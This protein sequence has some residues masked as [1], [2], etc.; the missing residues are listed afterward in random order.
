MQTAAPNSPELSLPTKLAYSV[1]EACS[2]LS[3]GKTTIYELI[4]TGRLRVVRI[5]NRTLVTADAL[6]ALLNAEDV[7]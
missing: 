4:K 7:L 1:K 5:G 6:R 3:I 2:A